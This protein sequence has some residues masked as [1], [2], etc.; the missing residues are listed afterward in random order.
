MVKYLTV[1][2]VAEKLQVTER[3]VYRYI[4]EEELPAAKIGGAWR[5]KERDLEKFF[6]SHKA[7]W[8]MESTINFGPN[9]KQE[10]K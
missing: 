10:D 5:I 8:C 2:D 4:H 9:N 3:T 6:N 1:E 7:D